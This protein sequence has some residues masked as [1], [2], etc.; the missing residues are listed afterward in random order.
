MVALCVPITCGIWLE[1]EVWFLTA[2]NWICQFLGG[3][4]K[5]I[6]DDPERNCYWSLAV[7]WRTATVP[8]LSLSLLRMHMAIWDQSTWLLEILDGYLKFWMTTWNLWMCWPGTW[9]LHLSFAW[10]QLE[11][12]MCPDVWLEVN[13]DNRQMLWSLVL[14]R[15]CLTIA[16]LI[17]M[18]WWSFWWLAPNKIEHWWDWFSGFLVWV[19]KCATRTRQIELWLFDN[20]VLPEF[21]DWST[22][23]FD[24]RS[25]CVGVFTPQPWMKLEHEEQHLVKFDPNVRSCLM[26][27]L[28]AD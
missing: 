2:W 10:V 13:L 18:F 1:P 21:C 4:D 14:P 8:T 20:G 6:V 12:L 5:R 7:V 17:A 26:R 19:L 11:H 16:Q 15:N 25:I 22:S 23:D 3:L 27:S 9:V 24:V 28:G